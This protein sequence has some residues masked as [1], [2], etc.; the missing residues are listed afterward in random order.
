MADTLTLHLS[1]DAW[2]GDAQ[3]AVLVDGT[4]IGGPSSVTTAHSTGTFQDF[5]YTGEFGSGPHTVEVQ[6][7]NDAWG[8]T[9]DTDRNLYVGGIT[10]DGTD[11]AGQTAQNT[12]FNGGP[13]SDPH[14]A[15]MYVN[16][17][18]V[19]ADVGSANPSPPPPPV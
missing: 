14:A 16:G 17:S 2:N 9:A 7:L 11:Y 10:F 15:E 6:F 3:F 12:A 8:G 4:E 5:T 13:D 19:F 18:T 1:E